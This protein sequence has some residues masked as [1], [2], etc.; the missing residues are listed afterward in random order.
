MGVSAPVEANW[1]TRGSLVTFC[2]GL[3]C[4]RAPRDKPLVGLAVL[5]RCR[6]GCRSAAGFQDGPALLG[7]EDRPRVVLAAE[8]LS[9]AEPGCLHHR[10]T[11]QAEKWQVEG[12]GG[13]SVPFVAITQD[14]TPPTPGAERSG[15]QS[16]WSG[17]ST[18]VEKT[19]SGRLGLQSFQ[20]PSS[21]DHEGERA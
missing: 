20:R 10:E 5:G 19:D 7:R 1:K 21:A 4:G 16:A 11:R 18:G 6:L 13:I 3:R 15:G 17:Q 14:E 8:T 9:D 12:F 2:R